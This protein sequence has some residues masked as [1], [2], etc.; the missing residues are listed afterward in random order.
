MR[1]VFSCFWLDLLTDTAALLRSSLTQIV[2]PHL[3]F[4]VGHLLASAELNPWTIAETPSA[5]VNGLLT[6][7]RLSEALKISRE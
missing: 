1:P 6:L 4:A 7:N 3:T 5:L 2:C